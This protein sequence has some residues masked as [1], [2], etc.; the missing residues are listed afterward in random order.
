[1]STLGKPAS[2]PLAGN[3]RRALGNITNT[4]SRG[5]ENVP[6]GQQATK[7]GLNGGKEGRRALGDIT[8]S[9][10]SKSTSRSNEPAKS[11]LF[12]H[13]TIQKPLNPVSAS[14]RAPLTTRSK[15]DI[16]ADDG[17][18]HLAGKSWVELEA[19]RKQRETADIENRVRK[20]TM[21]LPVWRPTITC[22]QVST[23]A[24]IGAYVY[25]MF[26]K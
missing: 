4:S 9:A 2:Q 10:L 7:P 3:V 5:S 25:K 16:Y 6:A 14:T 1:M 13:P 12:Q 24:Y 11:K 17:I 8:N 26:N 23:E 15:A 18:E 22:C 21:G 20:L 19:E